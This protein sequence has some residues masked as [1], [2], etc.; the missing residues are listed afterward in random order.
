MAIVDLSKLFKNLHGKIGG[1]VFRRMRDGSIV[2]GSAP[3]YKKKATPAQNVYRHET[4]R[5]RTQWA[6]WAA[7]EYPI[8]AQLAAERPMVHA[9]NMAISDASHPPVIHRILRKDGRILVNAWDE[10]MVDKVRVNIHDEH[11]KLLEV[12]DA[13]QIE[14]DW[15]EYT[16]QAKGRVSACALDLP[17][18]KVRMELE[19]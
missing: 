10:I 12:G 3:Q 2:V 16:P 19:E 5:E 4:F 14:K 7:K 1:L 11:G 17:G 8:Y 18:N 6:K 15:W 9:C 13:S